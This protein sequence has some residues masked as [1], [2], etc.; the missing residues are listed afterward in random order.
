MNSE[1]E[2]RSPES[3]H[4]PAIV[5]RTPAGVRFELNLYEYRLALL[6]LV[7]FA[8]AWDVLEQAASFVVDGPAK[9]MIVRDHL[10]PLGSHL[11]ALLARGVDSVELL[12]ARFW[13]RQEKME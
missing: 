7:D 11:P 13:F 10:R 12:A 2:P 9:A 1:H 4:G 5:I 6:G 3:G 8:G